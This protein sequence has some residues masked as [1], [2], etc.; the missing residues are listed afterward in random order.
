MCVRYSPAECAEYGWATKFGTLL[1]YRNTRTKP[2]AAHPSTTYLI[3]RASYQLHCRVLQLLIVV[4][5]QECKKLVQLE[6]EQT[7][8]CIEKS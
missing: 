1:Y 3:H 2:S 6:A 8:L 5:E 7:S 4:D